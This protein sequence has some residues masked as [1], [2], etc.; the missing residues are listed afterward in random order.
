MIVACR[1]TTR[2]IE[3]RRVDDGKTFIPSTHVHDIKR[4]LWTGE[5]SEENYKFDI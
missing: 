2:L 5:V 3:L 4:F 1:L